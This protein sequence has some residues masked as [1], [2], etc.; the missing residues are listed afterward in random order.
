M[1]IIAELETLKKWF[2]VF[3]MME[4]QN[5]GPEYPLKNL[6]DQALHEILKNYE[7]QGT[8]KGVKILTNDL[9]GVEYWGNRVVIRN[10]ANHDKLEIIN[11]K[12]GVSIFVT[13]YDKQGMSVDMKTIGPIV[14]KKI[15][16]VGIDMTGPCD[17]KNGKGVEMEINIEFGDDDD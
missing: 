10:E 7:V 12:N 14:G 5:G 6:I 17:C 2:A 15:T 13:K 4:T 8:E 11:Y 16:N 3:L 9:T 1:S